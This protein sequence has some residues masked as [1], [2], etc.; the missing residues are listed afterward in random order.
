[1][2]GFIRA[3]RNSLTCNENFLLRKYHCG[4]C[5]MLREEFGLISA[6]YAGWDG[7]FLAL[8][9]DSQLDSRS[10]DRTTRCPARLGIRC[11]Y[12]AGQNIAL[13]FAAAVT[14]C[15]AHQKY[16]DNAKDEASTIAKM[17]E[18]LNRRRFEKA[19]SILSK[20]GLP[21]PEI[22]S[23]MNQQQ[24][25][26]SHK[27]HYDLNDVTN[28][29]ATALSLIFAHTATVA[30]KTENYPILLEIGKRVGRL[31]TLLDACYDYLDD[32]QKGN[33]N[34]ITATLPPN[35]A[36]LQFS[37]EHFNILENYLLIQLKEIRSFVNEANFTRNLC[38]VNNF[39]IM[40]LFDSTIHA[41][42]EISEFI[43]EI[44]KCSEIKGK[45]P[46][47]GIVIESRFCPSCGQNVYYGKAYF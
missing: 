16:K 26:E 10:Q 40:G 42:S 46:S 35:S 8:L 12:I 1:M 15:L 17:G 14:I 37:Q 6:V 41:C 27:K 2:F 34:A 9:L 18:K 28:P 29:A 11:K 13:K 47:C 38:L 39:L 24:E 7:R 19:V 5:H 43:P 31:V 36:T 25:L 4:L 20:Q 22:K 33:Y 21:Y 44:F 30:K 3:R 32:A 45:C 23:A